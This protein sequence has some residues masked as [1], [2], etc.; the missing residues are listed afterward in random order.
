MDCSRTVATD[1]AERCVFGPEEISRR[2]HD[3]AKHGWHGQFGDN[4]EVG[5]Q[6]PAEALLLQICLLVLADWAI[7]ESF[8]N[9]PSRGRAANQQFSRC[10][11]KPGLA[12]RA[13]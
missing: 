8:P 11:F 6:Q 7:P 4:C 5:G 1:H 12:K 9:I 13:T 10:T 2:L 3:P